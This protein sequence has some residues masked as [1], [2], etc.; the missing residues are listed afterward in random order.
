LTTVDKILLTWD[1]DIIYIIRRSGY[2]KMNGAWLGTVLRGGL[3]QRE[4]LLSFG[5]GAVV[6]FL[7][8]SGALVV[9]LGFSLDRVVA[10]PYS[11]GSIGVRVN[12]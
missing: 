2:E 8:T 10:A 6:F 12:E 5:A 7:Y 9:H 11:G 3:S 4:G 1:L